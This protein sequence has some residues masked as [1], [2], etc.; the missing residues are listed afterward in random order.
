MTLSPVVQLC[1]SALLILSSAPMG[2]SKVSLDNT[3]HQAFLNAMD[4]EESASSRVGSIRADSDAARKNLFFQKIMSEAKHI[5]GRDLAANGDDEWQNFGFD[6]TEYSIKY[7]GC[8]TVKSYSDELAATYAS[9]V[10]AANRF[11]IFRLCPSFYCNKYTVTGCTLDYGEYVVLMDTYLEAIQ[12][13]TADK[14]ENFCAFCD[15]CL[16]YQSNETYDAS[17]NCTTAGEEACAGAATTCTDSAT[18]F[19]EYFQCKAVEFSDADNG[20][21]YIAP[22]CGSDGFTITLGIFSDNQCSNYTAD[23]FTIEEVTGVEFDTSELNTYFPKECVSCKEQSNI[24]DETASDNSDNDQVSEVCELLY[25]SSAKCHKNYYSAQEASYN[26]QQQSD[27]ENMVCNFISNLQSGSYDETGDIVLDANSWFFNTSNWRSSSEYA[28]QYNNVRAK[29]S[30]AQIAA[31]VLVATA[32]LLMWIWACCL[33]GALSKKNI[34][35]RPRRGK[36]AYDEDLSR[37]NSGIVMGRS[38]S[39]A[40]GSLI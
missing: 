29:V 31:L 35:W 15:K 39:G 12:Q 18:V 33:H 22:H 21:L 25:S 4:F 27:N 9:T 24:W 2:E 13:Y 10:L 37:Q 17:F 3:N 7:S 19:E 23:T 28:K 38:R 5:G 6:I 36:H 16:A 34:S 26:S 30:P 1:L 20:M 32:C 40:N 8:S 14:K 11:V